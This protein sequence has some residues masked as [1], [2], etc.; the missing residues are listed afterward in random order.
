[1]ALKGLYICRSLSI[2]SLVVINNCVLFFF[3]TAV[4][5]AMRT[6]AGT[7]SAT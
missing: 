6:S 4:N 3:F 7:L 5:D 1:M 2:K